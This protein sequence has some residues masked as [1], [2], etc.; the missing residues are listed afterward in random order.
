MV[1]P[2]FR[3]TRATTECKDGAAESLGR[4]RSA[5]PARMKNPGIHKPRIPTVHPS[6]EVDR[7][8]LQVPIYGQLAIYGHL[9]APSSRLWFPKNSDGS[10]VVPS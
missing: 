9:C 1:L 4:Q 2:A 3:K 10:I 6:P 8:P 7:W 5:L